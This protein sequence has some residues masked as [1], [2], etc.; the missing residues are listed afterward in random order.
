MNFWAPCDLLGDDF[1]TDHM[2]AVM[3]PRLP[4]EILQFP[5]EE[6]EDDDD[7]D[8]YIGGLWGGRKDFER[9]RLLALLPLLP[10]AALLATE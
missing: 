5:L 4:Y 2:E 10:E 9:L 8:E 3:S 7:D 1:S 6:E